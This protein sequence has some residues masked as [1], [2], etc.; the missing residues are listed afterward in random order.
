MFSVPPVL[1]LPEPG[2][3]PCVP[4]DRDVEP[5]FPE[6]PDDELPLL[7]AAMTDTAATRPTL[8]ANAWERFRIETLLS[9]PCNP[10]EVVHGGAV[11]GGRF[12]LRA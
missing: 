9:I 12:S 1:G 5:E 2:L 10:H 11:T 3:R 7:H 8:E 4:D 6:P